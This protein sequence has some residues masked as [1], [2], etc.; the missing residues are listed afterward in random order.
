MAEVARITIKIDTNASK[1]ARD[2]G[3]LN[4]GT[5]QSEQSAKGL[6]GA[7]S[8]IKALGIAAI[9]AK[10]AQSIIQLGRATIQAASDS[11]ETANR[12]NT[13]FSGISSDAQAAAENLQENFGLSR[14]AAQDLLASTGDLLT[15]FGFTQEAALGLSDQANQL[16]IDLASFTN[17]PIE[18][19]SRAITSALTGEV[20][21]L[22]SLGIVVRQGTKEFRDQVSAIQE[23][24]GVTESQ[25]RAQ[26]ILQEAYAQ[27][28][29]AIGDFERSQDSYANTQRTTQAAIEDLSATIGRSIIPAATE[30]SR[31][32]GKLAR[33]IDNLLTFDE[34]VQE[35]QDSF[36]EVQGGIEDLFRQFGTSPPAEAFAA[37][38]E[39]VIAAADVQRGLVEQL[40]EQLEV[41]GRLNFRRRQILDIARSRLEAA[42][43]V[44]ATLDTQLVAFDAIADEAE[45]AAQASIERE[46]AERRAAELLQNQLSLQER[47]ASALNEYASEDDQRVFAINEEIQS[48]VDLRSEARELGVAYGDLQ[49]QI[50]TLVAERDALIE[51]LSEEQEIVEALT[52]EQMRSEGM[53]EAYA[54]LEEAAINWGDSTVLQFERVAEAAQVTFDQVEAVASAFTSTLGAFSDLRKA[55]IA[56][57]EAAL[58]ARGATEEEVAAATLQSRIKLARQEKAQ[59]TFSAIIS[60]ASSIASALA[61][62]K[63]NPVLAAIL[64]SLYAAQ[65]AVQIAAIQSQPIPQ[66]QFGG[67]FQVP[68][69]MNQDGGLLRVNSGER[70]DVTPARGGGGQQ[71]IKLQLGD[72][73]FTQVVEDVF[74][75]K[76]GQIRNSNAVRLK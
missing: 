38:R 40:E 17:V 22:K 55:Q 57:E 3:K 58:R 65:G 34:Q 44:R 26:V 76:G 46:E 14:R 28:G 67:S 49:S 43:G 51:S 70:V 21:A 8:S 1:A 24:T 73:E 13:V 32:I 20:E 75:R 9:A 27:S 5:Q 16:A 7:W 56:S 62:S 45:R 35:A 19:S 72:R 15:G 31:I 71:V 74:N 68:P 59:A 25:A 47:I 4:A 36:L 54:A 41:E 52:P 29:N 64:T 50:N 61:F 2:M 33:E 48:L 66:A 69:G 18:Q 30:A 11:E 6:R 23:A 10:A 42:E 60:T 63:G 37:Y 39:E 12:F 53:A